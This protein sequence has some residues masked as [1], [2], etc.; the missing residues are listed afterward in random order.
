MTIRGQYRK[1]HL[2][3]HTILVF[4]VLAVIFTTALT[5]AGL[6]GAQTGKHTFEV[7]L[8][9]YEKVEGWEQV[10]WP[11]PEKTP[12]WIS[13]EVVL[14]NADIARAYPD[15]TPEGKPC[16]G[17][18]FTEEGALKIARLTRSHIGKNTAIILDGRVT[19]VP[20][21]KEEI[22]GGRA[23][24]EG[25]FTEEET[26][27]IAKGLSGDQTGKI[28]FESGKI[29]FEVRLASYERVEGW[30][31]GLVPGPP[32]TPV[33]ISPE[34]ALTNADIARAWP[35]LDAG[36]FCVGFQLTEE[37]SLKLARLTKSHIGENVA[38]MVDGRVMS[39]PKI[40]AEITG[41]RAMINGKFTEE[42]A[43]L[44]AKGIMMK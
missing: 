14:T 18:V 23:I 28:N 10:P 39:A 12:L 1:R 17:V 21:I 24:I 32:K 33:W 6:S 13:P 5:A 35:Q 40:M 27:S 16:V 37:G 30:E 19:M 25:N 4:M 22:T 36:G 26:E 7:R 9:S 42:E 34:A 31:I 44:L 41:G 11:G 20:K 43:G 38:I 8:A 2:Y 29:A 15:Q 3:F